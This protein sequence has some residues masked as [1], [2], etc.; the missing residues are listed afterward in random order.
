M[1]RIY[2][3]YAAYVSIG[4]PNSIFYILDRWQLLAEFL[5]DFICYPVFADPNGF[6]DVLQGILGNQVVLTLA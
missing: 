2:P 1:R 5:E 4:I 6:V 3:K